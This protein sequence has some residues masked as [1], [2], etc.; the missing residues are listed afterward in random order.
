[1]LAAYIIV[2]LTAAVF[3]PSTGADT[4]E[5]TTSDTGLS[6]ERQADPEYWE[7]CPTIDAELLTPNSYSRPQIALTEINAIVIHYTAN[8]GS[9]AMANRNYF[10]NLKNGTGTK[11]SSHFIVGLDGEVVQCIPSSEIAYANY[12][13]NGDTLSIECCHPDETGKFGDETRQTVVELAA[14]LCK[15]FSVDPD[16]VIRHYDVSGKDCPK[17]YAENES[18]WLS[19]KED[20]KTQYQTLVN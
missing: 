2:R 8:P 16:N 20:I 14:W 4:S 15:A 19:L 18:E 3:Y 1:M 6:A 5:Q 11:A 7:G 9:T 17:Y 13:R 12:P 10:E